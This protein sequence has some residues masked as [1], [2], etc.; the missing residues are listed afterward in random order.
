MMNKRM[1]TKSPTGKKWHI[2]LNTM[3]TICNR[4]CM[5]WIATDE[6]Q[7]SADVCKQCLA[8]YE[9]RLTGEGVPF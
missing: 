4:L 8:I 3:W 7:N 5:A 1:Y 6:S 9:A 2:E